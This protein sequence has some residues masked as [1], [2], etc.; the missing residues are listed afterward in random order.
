MRWSL[1]V[2]AF[3]PWL[4][5]W[6]RKHSNPVC[7]FLSTFSPKKK[8]SSG[9]IKFCIFLFFILFFPSNSSIYNISQGIF[10]AVITPLC[11]EQNHGSLRYPSGFLLQ[12]H[13]VSTVYH[14]VSVRECTNIQWR[15]DFHFSTLSNLIA[16]LY[17]RHKE[18]TLI[19]LKML[20][21]RWSGG[22]SVN[23]TPAADMIF[24]QSHRLFLLLP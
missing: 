2:F 10:W 15:I 9:Q 4:S 5:P 3:K 12:L 13:M 1:R 22:T 16:Y 23:S 7:L 14:R 11:L 24:F 19:S 6:C 21:Q 17:N 20:W 8:Q 18:I